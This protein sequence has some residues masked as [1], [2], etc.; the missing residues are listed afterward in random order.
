MNNPSENSQTDSPGTSDSQTS[1]EKEQSWSVLKCFQLP[2]LLQSCSNQNC[3][4]QTD[5]FTDERREP[6]VSG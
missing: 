5:S 3:V 6:G 1:P 2:N 4:R